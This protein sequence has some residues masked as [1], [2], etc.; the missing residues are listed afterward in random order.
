MSDH[1][2]YQVGLGTLNKGKI[3]YLKVAS[4]GLLL[5]AA[6]GFNLL[7][8]KSYE[9]YKLERFNPDSDSKYD[10]FASKLLISNIAIYGAGALWLSDLLSVGININ[11]RKKEMLKDNNGRYFI[12]SISPAL[13]T[14]ISK[15]L[16]TR[17][18]YDIFIE[19]GD[20]LNIFPDSLYLARRAYENALKLRPQSS[21]AEIK[22]QKVNLEILNFEETIN[23]YQN[24]ISDGNELF[25]N[26]DFN[27]AMEIYQK[28]N[29]IK[30]NETYPGIKIRE[31]K[32]IFKEIEYKIILKRAQD[33]FRSEKY[34]ESIKIANE[35]LQLKPIDDEPSILIRNCE[36]KIKEREFEIQKEIYGK[37]INEARKAFNNERFS[38]AEILYIQAQELFPEE[39]QPKKMLE[40]IRAINSDLNNTDKL[41]KLY[42]ENIDGVVYIET[43]SRD[44]VYQG[45]GFIIS[46]DGYCVSNYHI[47]K[48]QP[49]GPIEMTDGYIKIKMELNLAIKYLILMNKRTISLSKFKMQIERILKCFKLQH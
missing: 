16:D 38:E 1:F 43:R 24:L 29:L 42:Q 19:R 22:L 8:K 25:R 47:F 15:E 2:F 33:L 28:A 32:I 14:S 3:N 49:K 37:I 30:P 41:S 23:K 5:G 12:P 45:T 17:D 7:A 46:E 36:I 31:I 35:A 4:A 27:R 13:F 10:D 20:M 6:V 40:R 34:E 26:Q 21:E 39:G 9:D 48:G 11:R 44:S 18:S